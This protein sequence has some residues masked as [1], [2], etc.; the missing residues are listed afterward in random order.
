MMPTEAI[1][2]DFDTALERKLKPCKGGA[3]YIGEGD[4]LI[5]F[6]TGEVLVTSNFTG[7]SIYKQLKKGKD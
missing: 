2:V 6:T 3:I 7:D 5:E 1:Q 4:H